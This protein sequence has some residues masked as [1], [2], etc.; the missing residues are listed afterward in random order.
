MLGTLATTTW[1]WWWPSDNQS[2]WRKEHLGQEGSGTK[3]FALLIHLVLNPH[4]LNFCYITI[5]RNILFS[6]Y[7]NVSAGRLCEKL[8]SYQERQVLLQLR[9]ATESYCELLTDF[10]MS[11]TEFL[12]KRNQFLSRPPH[13]MK[14]QSL[15]RLNELPRKT[16]TCACC[17]SGICALFLAWDLCLSWMCASLGCMLVWDV[18]LSGGA[19]LVVGGQNQDWAIIRH[20]RGRAGQAGCVHY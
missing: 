15:P 19:R 2:F 9:P 10:L 11:D 13:L 5:I 14:T 16:K 8:S 18:C 1:R 3:R 20:R 17:L 6:C 4:H 7:R 12:E